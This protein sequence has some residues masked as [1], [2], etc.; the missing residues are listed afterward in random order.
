MQMSTNVLTNK[1]KTVFLLLVCAHGF[2]AHAQSQDNP[3]TFV[4][5]KFG[6]VGW[7]N[8]SSPEGGVYVYGDEPMLHPKG[9]AF[10]LGKTQRF[11]YD[12]FSYQEEEAL[13]LV[14]EDQ[15]KAIETQEL[16]ERLA[17]RKRVH[18]SPQINWPKVVVRGNQVC[19]PLLESSEASDWKSHLTCTEVT[20]HD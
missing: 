10:T 5:T 4:L 20:D 17:L 2:C 19:V 7:V 11:D 18:K 1:V 13:W 14:R 3:S 6:S 15:L 16:G 8:I 12:F 9:A